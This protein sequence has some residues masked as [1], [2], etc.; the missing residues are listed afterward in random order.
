MGFP[1]KRIHHSD[2]R[3]VTPTYGEKC[4]RTTADSTKADNLLSLGP[5]PQKLVLTSN[6]KSPTEAQTRVGAS[7]VAAV[8]QRRSNLFQ[9][10][11]TEV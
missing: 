4:V 10:R 2:S 3:G 11:S 7:P 5:C 6:A 1:L 9:T 8:Q